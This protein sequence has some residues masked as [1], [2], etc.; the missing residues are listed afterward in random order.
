[1]SDRVFRIKYGVYAQRL[2]DMGITQGDL[3]DKAGTSP[4][5]LSDIVTGRKPRVSAAIAFAVAEAMGMAPGDLF[6]LVP[7]T[8]ATGPKEFAAAAL[9]A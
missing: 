9:P 1:M 4:Q 2:R 6:E 5:H 7:A 3:A 8:K